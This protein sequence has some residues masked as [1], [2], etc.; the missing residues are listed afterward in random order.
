MTVNY[1]TSN[2]HG[3]L[4]TQSSQSLFFGPTLWRYSFLWLSRKYASDVAAQV[5]SEL[6]PVGDESLPTV[7]VP[8]WEFQSQAQKKPVE[9]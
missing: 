5:V 3:R 1:T 6:I 9:N 7:A 8:E 4:G 2:I